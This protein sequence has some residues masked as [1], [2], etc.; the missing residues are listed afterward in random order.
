MSHLDTLY[1]ATKIYLIYTGV[2]KFG[3][4][5]VK[6]FHN[7]DAARRYLKEQREIY[8]DVKAVIYDREDDL[9]IW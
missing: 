3:D 9:T 7:R 5:Q 4:V 2:N 6:V 8:R 1:E